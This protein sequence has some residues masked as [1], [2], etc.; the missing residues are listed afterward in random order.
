MTEQPRQPDFGP[1]AIGEELVAK[2]RD[3]AYTAVGLGILGFQRLQVRRHDLVHR[4]GADSVAAR[5]V[6]EL[7]SVI[8][9]G[10]RQLDEWMEGTLALVDSGLEPIEGQLPPA[11]RAVVTR[12]RALGSQLHQIVK[13]VA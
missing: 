6:D 11:A 8:T 7:K 2:A 12:G 9:S 1:A 5:P 13:S 4:L 10:A 3:A